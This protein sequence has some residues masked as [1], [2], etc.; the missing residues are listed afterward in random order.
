MS[1][2]YTLQRLRRSRLI[3]NIIS[4]NL[5]KSGRIEDELTERRTTRLYA[6]LLS[7]TVTILIIYTALSLRTRST[8]IQLPSESEYQQ[9]QSEYPNTLRCPCTRISI[10]FS[11]LISLEPT[12]HQVCRSSFVSMEWINYLF[13]DNVSIAYGSSQDFRGWMSNQFQ[14]LRLFCQISE[15][16]VGD[17]LNLFQQ[18]RLITVNLI[19]RQLFSIQLHSSMALLQETTAN[20][21]VR[22]FRLM[23]N[24]TAN[25]GLMSALKTN[26]WPEIYGYNQIT[27]GGRQYPGKNNTF[28]SCVSMI[29]CELGER[30]KLTVNGFYMDCLIVE[31]LFSSSL[32]CLYNLSCIEAEIQAFITFSLPL[33]YSVQALNSSLLMNH[34]VDATVESMINN[35]ML[36]Q[37]HN[38]TNY[39]AYFE[40]CNSIQC[41]YS[42]TQRHDFLYIITTI[43]ACLGGLI[44]VLRTVS[45]LLVKHMSKVIQILLER[46]RS[47]PDSQ[48][49]MG[50]PSFAIGL[51][52]IYYMRSILGEV[53]MAQPSV[54]P[55]ERLRLWSVQNIVQLNLFKSD[56]VDQELRERKTTRL[57]LI[58]LIISLCILLSYT[59]FV[60]QI[61]SGNIDMTSLVQFEQL[62]QQYP[63]SLR[64]PCTQPAISHEHFISI[65]PTYH[66]ICHSD[67]TSEQ[68]L[69]DIANGMGLGEMGK[70]IMLLS[71]FCDL[72]THTITDALK[73]FYRTQIISADTLNRQLFELQTHSLVEQFIIDTTNQFWQTLQLMRLITNVNALA[74]PSR[75]SQSV[76]FA[77]HVY[78][79]S[80]N[81]ILRSTATNKRVGN[82]SCSCVTDLKCYLI[83][84]YS[85][86][87]YISL[88]GCYV[89]ETLLLLDMTCFF[90]V[91]CLQSTVG[92]V[93]NR[94]RPS[95]L[96][97]SMT[98]IFPPN[99]SMEI[100]MKHLM[101]EQ[102]HNSSHYSGFFAQCS[103]V[104]CA[105][106]YSRQY[107]ILYVITIIASLLGGL[108]AV[109]RFSCPLLFKSF[110]ICE[111]WI[112]ERF[113][114]GQTEIVVRIRPV[115]SHSKL[116]F[117]R[118]VVKSM[119]EKSTSN[120]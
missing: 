104:R 39:S 119:F 33:N 96:S 74:V 57:Y 45:L 120:R 92:A 85:N 55:F 28:C 2:Q 31:A 116:F 12:Y 95:P 117:S 6:L 106:T 65:R 82:R 107:D 102:W 25:N 61:E 99:A 52:D 50:K 26:Y 67:L 23:R 11:K 27:F 51:H 10:E 112:S 38:F 16:I 41:T 29:R 68:F 59:L 87:E 97:S 86:T 7:S 108:I 53:D 98:S 1:F 118:P 48:S 81:L 37:W 30:S 66:Q 8:S 115:N 111:K 109:L 56:N 101:V 4:L 32:A 113:K 5:F 17:A 46:M 64:C 93:Y 63:S 72:T 18:T 88:F 83:Q 58:L 44:K 76:S 71:A 14:A 62:Y 90:D 73:L 75:L 47:R 80:S 13:N 78:H 114:G 70:K 91:A 19:P 49:P 3:Q 36:E 100:I 42:Y 24:I 40:Q 20:Q 22:N 60:P 94:S 79:A 15:K 69:R 43:I 110:S 21:F 84:N 89:I 9:L 34:P 35:L 105:Y 103:P 77:E 54:S